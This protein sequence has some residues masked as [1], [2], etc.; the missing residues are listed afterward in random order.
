MSTSDKVMLTLVNNARGE[1]RSCGTTDYPAVSSV[2]WNCTLEQAAQGHSTSMAENDF[3]SHTGLDDSSPG[4]RI[5]AAGYTWRTY[6]ENIAAGFTDEES[7]MIGWLESPGH[8]ANIMNANFTEL[9]VAID[10]NPSSRY[11]IY[12]TQEFADSF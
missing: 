7:V 3:F 12:W 4:D 11:R 6:G 1:P 10:E 9:G 8:C 5:S 2:A